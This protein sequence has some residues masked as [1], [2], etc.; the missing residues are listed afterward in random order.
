MPLQEI[1]GY[2]SFQRQITLLFFL[3]IQIN[4]K[5]DIMVHVHCMHHNVSQPNIDSSI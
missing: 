5:I 2:D 1:P 4:T 3:R